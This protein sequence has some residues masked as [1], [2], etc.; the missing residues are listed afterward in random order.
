[1]IFYGTNASRLKEGVLN[2]V[3]CPACGDITSMNYTVFGKY[4]YLYWIPVFPLGKTTVLECNSCKTTFKLKELPQQIQ[5]KFEIERHRGV[6]LKH[7]AGL[8]IILAFVSWALYANA[9]NK[10][11]EAIYIDAPKV[12]DIYHTEGSSSSYYTSAKVI[13][14]EKDSVFLVYNDYETNKKSGISDIDKD[15]NYSLVEDP[16]GLTI[17]NIKQ[18]YEDE[19]IFKIERDE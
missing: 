10:E 11:N 1:M 17:A 4:A 18:L 8:F 12:G 2:N 7:F 14:I 6:P 5:Q 15:S 16:Y 3:T 13:A 19:V 9:K